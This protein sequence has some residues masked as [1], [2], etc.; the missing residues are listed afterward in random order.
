MRHGDESI[1]SV[2]ELLEHLRVHTNGLDAPTW[3]RGQSKSSW[4]LI[5][6][7]LRGTTAQSET[8][9]IS[10]FKQNATLLLSQ[11]PRNDF[12][13]LFLMQHISMQKFA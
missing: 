10:K 12:E 8:Y 6:K 1:N 2:G 11:P 7:L 4:P 9:L 13:W 5:P 3:F